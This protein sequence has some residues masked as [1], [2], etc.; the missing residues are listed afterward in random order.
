[1]IVLTTLVSNASAFWLRLLRQAWLIA[2]LAAHYVFDVPSFVSFASALCF[3]VC[4]RQ[5]VLWFDCSEKLAC[6]LCSLRIVLVIYFRRPSH[7]DCALCSFTAG[8]LF[9]LCCGTSA[10]ANLLT[11][12]LDTPASFAHKF[13]E[14]VVMTCLAISVQAH[15]P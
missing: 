8:V 2:L 11:S 10:A 3:V 4:C 6:S 7:F 14:T 13:V 15:P 12:L 5:S 9:G 1:M